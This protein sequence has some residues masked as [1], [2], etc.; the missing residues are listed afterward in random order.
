MTIN[1]DIKKQYENNYSIDKE[2]LILNKTKEKYNQ[3]K[4]LFE[5]NDKIQLNILDLFLN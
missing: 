1:R 5:D 3:L 4:V 2:Q